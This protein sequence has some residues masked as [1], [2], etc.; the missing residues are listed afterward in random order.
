[1]QLKKQVSLR[2]A[3]AMATTTLLGNVAN[4]AS[5]DNGWDVDSSILYY[6]E[7]DR[8]TVIKPVIEAKK[9]LG[10]DEI[11]TV[12]GVIDSL[13]GASPNG[14]IPQTTAQTFTSASGRDSYTVNANE[15]P[16][17]PSFEDRRYAL[18]ASW[19]KPLTRLTKTV[20]GVNGSTETDY[21]SL[22][23]IATLSSDFNQRNT[24]VTAALAVNKDTIEPFNGVP[25]PFSPMIVGIDMQSSGTT[26][27]KSVID[28][29]FGV[30]QV[31]NRTT[32][33]Q[34]N[35]NIGNDAGYLTDP[36]KIISVTNPGTPTLRGVNPYLY[37][38]RPDSRRR[39]ALYGKL[40]KNL[41]GDVLRTSYRYYQ[42]SW[43]IKSHTVDAQYQWQLAELQYLQPHFRFYKQSKAD[44]YYYNLEDGTLP[45][46]ASADY[47]LGDLET[48]TA[49]F[50]YGYSL[51]KD[52]EL[53][54]R[55]EHMKQAAAGDD[56]FPD[57]EANFI[58]LGFITRF[59]GF[60]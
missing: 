15:T 43:G 38:H 4:A 18:N 26:E 37:E 31:I 10:D 3:L 46:F 33:A 30:T 25:I 27:N 57:V 39:Q 49:G 19:D 16:M 52:S 9:N 2:Q 44:F 13:S 20:L 22:G 24:T 54:V 28:T 8:I 36:Y 59:N 53:S 40:I 35:L 42:D 34:L 45:E 17:E 51:G 21:V 29:L 55:L 1:M 47:R 48:S 11:I 56:P 41:G 12:R 32:I 50:K 7:V 14:A 6:S 60:W 58:Q 23:L 5:A